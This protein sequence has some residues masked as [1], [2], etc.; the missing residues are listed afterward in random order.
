MKNTANKCLSG[1]REC[2]VR[3]VLKGAGQHESRWA[4][5][6]SKIGCAPQTLKEWIKKVEI[7]TGRRGG[8]MTEFHTKGRMKRG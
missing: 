8:I 6:V 5:I 2:A 3:M 7:D 1:V 4:T